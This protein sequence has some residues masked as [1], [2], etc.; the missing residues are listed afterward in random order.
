MSDIRTEFSKTL[1]L[2][3]KDTY[4]EINKVTEEISKISSNFLKQY[5]IDNNE[6][7]TKEI[8][9]LKEN[10]DKIKQY[11]YQVTEDI[12][13]W[14]QFTNSST[15]IRKLSFPIKFYWKRLKLSKKIN[16]INKYIYRISIENRLI[17]E[18]LKKIERSIE[19]STLQHIKNSGIYKEY[20]ELLRIKETS[21]SDL[22]YLLPT[23]PSSPKKIDL[24]DI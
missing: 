24:N 1:L 14:Y 20:E 17:K 11:N 12:N 10:I 2:N 16:R 3:L 19:S 5:Y 13:K 9:K 18:G 23:L 22:K 4:E 7:I 8:N 21:L 15:E 6:A